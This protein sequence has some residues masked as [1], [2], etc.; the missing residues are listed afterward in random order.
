MIERT[1]V[2]GRPATVAY[3]TS[4]MQPADKDKADFARVLFDDGDS[5]FLAMQPQ[6]VDT[7]YPMLDFMIREGF[8]LTRETYLNICY[9]EPPE[10]TA[11][12]EATLPPIFRSSDDSNEP[13]ERK[14]PASKP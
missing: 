14:M 11:E 6:K 10:I 13:M 3:V 5:A 2:S 9:D 7:G 4:D 8:P 1:T 12:L